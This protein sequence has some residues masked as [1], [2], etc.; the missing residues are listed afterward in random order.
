ML[1]MGQM[2]AILSV[3]A[4][5]RVC[6]GQWL[7]PPDPRRTMPDIRAAEKGVCGHCGRSMSVGYGKAWT[8]VCR[9]R[10]SETDC[11]PCMTIGG[12][13]IDALVA[14]KFLEAVSASGI[15]AAAQAFEQQRQQGQDAHRTLQLEVDRCAY[16]ASLAERRYRKIDPDNRLVADTLER[17]WN[18]ALLAL[19]AARDALEQARPSGPA[20][21]GP[22]EPIGNAAFRTLGGSRGHCPGP[23]AS[24]FL[25]GGGGCA[26]AGRR[27]ENDPDSCALARGC[28]G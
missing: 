11:R 2:A 28:D 21:T 25:P 18:D 14:G 27:G 5:R 13:R 10:I 3:L 24:S 23:Q 4:T 8:Y 15:E 6:D 12:K 22:A 9:P 16:D 20:I 7:P 17:D 26:L 19:A 1:R